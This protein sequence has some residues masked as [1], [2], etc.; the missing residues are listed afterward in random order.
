MKM[1]SRVARRSFSTQSAINSL[2]RVARVSLNAN[3]CE[4]HGDDES[5][6]RAVAPEA[7]VYVRSTEEAQAVV[8]IC[9]ETRTPIIPFGTGTSLEGHI[10]ANQGGISLDLSEMNNVLE[11]NDEDLDC[12]VQ[13]GVTRLALNN[14]LRETG[15]HFPVDPGADASLGGMVACSASGTNSVKYGT[16]KENT[17]GLTAVLASGEI[18]R[19][20][21]ARASRPPATISHGCLSDPKARSAS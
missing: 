11:V 16:M 3:I 4:R 13:G 10:Q 12:R 18:V 7:V 14:H 19:T 15:L 8:R 17:L 1:L 20:A 6:H 5:H 21:A 9:A 2:E